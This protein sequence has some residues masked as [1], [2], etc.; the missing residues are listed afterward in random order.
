[1]QTRSERPVGSF[2]GYEAMPLA[3]PPG[4]IRLS[5]E[6]P[7]Q[8]LFLGL[9][10]WWVL[11]V[12]G[13]IQALIAVPMLFAL[14]LRGRSAMPR[15]FAVWLLF[16]FWMLVTVIQIDD[17]ARAVSFTWRASIYIASGVIFLYVYNQPRRSLP[18]AKV[19]RVMAGFWMLTTLGGTIGMLLPT[20]S[21]ASVTEL[22][23]PRSI[24][25][26]Q[27]VYDLVHASTASPRAFS[28]TA[29]HRPKLPF[30][31]TNQWGSMFAMTLPFCLAAIGVARSKPSRHLLWATLALSA[32]PLA[33]SLDRGA[34]LSVAISMGYALFVLTFTGGRRHA[35]TAVTLVFVGLVAGTIV[36]VTPLWDVIQIRL[37]KGYG[38]Q[39]RQVL[40]QESIKAV[41]LSPI[42]G[43]GAPIPTTVTNTAGADVALSV[44]TH[45]QGWTVVVSHGI[46]GAVLFI[47]WWV[48][49]FFKTRRRIPAVEGRDPMVRFWAH[50]VVLAALVQMPYYQLMPW[51]LPVMMVAAAIAMR[52]AR[53]DREAP[54][55]LPSP[56]RR[57]PLGAAAR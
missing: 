35:R 6:W 24:S 52:E 30:A 16:L 53:P 3:E 39:S 41:E 32:V 20:I 28:F 13:F 2:P 40:Y 43:F 22:L 46:P 38:D 33:A 37:D 57:I 51:G 15:S 5:P 9:F 55:A 47:A 17:F 19:V 12:G 42:L 44:G 34:W 18:T 31:Y 8:V 27:F 26:N 23:L 21:F 29:L 10:A 14:V 49:V 1:V 48:G 36:L 45:G 11:G 56:A 50:V 4:S 25:A 54:G 7:L